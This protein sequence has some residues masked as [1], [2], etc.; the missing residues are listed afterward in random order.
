MSH[1]VRIFSGLSQC[2]EEFVAA[3]ANDEIGLANLLDRSIGNALQDLVSGLMASVSMGYG[4]SVSAN[5]RLCN[6]A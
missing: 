5:C 1:L 2:D 4:V 3:V 6:A